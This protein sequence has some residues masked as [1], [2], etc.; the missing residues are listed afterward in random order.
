LNTKVSEVAERIIAADAPLPVSDDAGQ[1]V[2]SIDR[3][4]VAHVL[5]GQGEPG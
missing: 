1:V 4:A 5:F 2:G 3:K